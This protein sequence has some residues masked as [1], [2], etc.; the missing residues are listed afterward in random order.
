MVK[1][2]QNNQKIYIILITSMYIVS[3]PHFNSMPRIIIFL[4]APG[5]LNLRN[6]R[7]AIPL[8]FLI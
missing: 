7:K 3:F 4:G 5:R 6:I 8:S 2:Q 1:N